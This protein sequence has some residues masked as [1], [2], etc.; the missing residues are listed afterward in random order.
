[1]WKNLVAVAL[2]VAALVCASESMAGVGSE[3][4]RPDDVAWRGAPELVPAAGGLELRFAGAEGATGRWTFSLL[5]PR[6]EAG[7]TL[8]VVASPGSHAVTVAR[9]RLRSAKGQAGV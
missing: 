2:C 4:L 9:P 6:G 7:A 5:G 3:L 8:S 1:M